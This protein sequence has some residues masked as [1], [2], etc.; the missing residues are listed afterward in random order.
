MGIPQ[1]AFI[2]GPSPEWEPSAL[3][4]PMPATPGKIIQTDR[5]RRRL[6]KDELARGL[7]VPKHRLEALRLTGRLL[8]ET[9]SLHIL[10]YLTPLL[11]L[12]LSPPG[13]S[14]TVS[15]RA[16]GGPA[17]LYQASSSI[18]NEIKYCLQRS[19][20]AAYLFLVTS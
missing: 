2:A 18:V 7:G 1:K 19:T 10:E 9:T 15:S 14:P 3:V 13:A 4:D 16:G 11:L 17:Q 8:S 12:E 6:L 5:G 20:R